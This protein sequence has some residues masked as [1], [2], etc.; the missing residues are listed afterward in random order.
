MPKYQ[1]RSFYPKGTPIYTIGSER[2]KF[3]PVEPVGCESDEAGNSRSD[4][5]STRL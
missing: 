4:A 5:R 3:T 1:I 2:S